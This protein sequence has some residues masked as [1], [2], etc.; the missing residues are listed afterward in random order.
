MKA[1]LN[2]HPRRLAPMGGKVHLTRANALGQ[3][4]HGAAKK[5]RVTAL[6][7]VAAAT[8]GALTL[9]GVTAAVAAVPAEIGPGVGITGVMDRG[10][11]WL[12]AVGGTAEAEA[13]GW[14]SWCISAG[15]LSPQGAPAVSVSYVDDPQLAW[16]IQAYEHVGTDV[17]RAAIAYLTHT[18]HETGSN[19][20][21][22]ETR[23]ARIIANTPQSVK[24]VAG[25]YI[26]EAA[27]K[28]GPYTAAPGGVDGA[29]TRVGTIWASPV[30]SNSGAPLVGL[31]MTVTLSGPAVFDTNGNADADRGET[32]VWN[33]QTPSERMPLKWVATGN[34]EVTWNYSYQALPRTTLTRF[35]ATGEVQDTLTYGAR[36]PSDPEEL[37][38]PGPPFQVLADF[39]P[40]IRTQ[41]ATTFV[42][43]GAA[44]VDQVTVAP[45]AGDTWAQINGTHV[46]VTAQ[47]TLYGPYAAPPARSATVPAGAPV[48]GTAEL[49][50][51][52][53]ST[54]DAA[55]SAVARGSGYYTW[56]WTIDK[57][58]QGPNGVYVRAD[59][60]HDF[61]LVAETHV[62]P[63]QPEVTTVV[64][65]RFVEKGKAFVDEVTFAPAA[66]D[67]WLARQ[68]GTPVETVWDGTLYGPFLVP[69]EQVDT[70]P[71]AAPV[72]ATTILIAS[73]AG[74]QSTDAAATASAPGFYTW[75]WEMDKATQ[76]VTSQPYIAGSVRTSFM[77][78][79]ET[80]SVRHTAAISTMVRDFNV[81]Q[82]GQIHDLV[83]VSGL[84]EDHSD[85]E[86]LGG[87]TGDVDEITHT[88]YG[89]LAA[90]PT[91]DL[92]LSTAPVL[93][94]ATSPAKNGSHVV[95]TGGEFQVAADNTAAGW[96]VVVSSFPGDD[97][98][99]A[100]ATSPGDR[101]EM[102]FV[103]TDRTTDVET[104]LV[105]DADAQVPAGQP[106][107]DTAH[108]TGTTVEGGYLEFEAYGPF[109]E[110]QEPAESPET[111]LW[112]SEQIP[113][114][115][116]GTYRSGVVTAELPDGAPW[117]DVYWVAAYYGPDSERIVRG[118]LG[119]PSE[120]TRVVEQ[121]EPLVT[122]LA[123]PESV[124]GSPSH[125]VAYV[126]G[127]VV[128]ASTLTFAAYRQH[129][130]DDVALDELVVDTSNTPTTIYHG[131]TYESPEVTFDAPGTYY[132]V[133]TLTG[134]DGEVLHVG[135][136]RL[137]G[138]TT[139]VVDVPVPP[140]AP[141]HEAAPGA[142]ASTGAQAS[143][144][145]GAALLML[146]AGLLLASIAQHRAAARRLV[147][148]AGAGDAPGD[149][150]TLPRG[151]L[152]GSASRT[153]GI[154]DAPDPSPG[155]QP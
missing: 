135:E 73:E 32:R 138:E 68:D 58:A 44:L 102:A 59:A 91:D 54:L 150:G 41:V 76:P 132:W 96:Y 110:G 93:G 109:V 131:G 62:V 42:D 120:I 90:Q 39:Q 97:R 152:G 89:P 40:E 149:A 140:V 85:F 55:A 106:F 144:A 145:A 22:A 101:M 61:G 45:A 133:E 98:L 71:G 26:A 29:G 123:V 27:S 35:K 155:R 119:D 34:G 103:P 113:A 65:E 136:P 53:P 92:D 118:E 69:T 153:A 14:L 10:T 6:S 15:L 21:P 78:E 1:R 43:K 18:R 115:R 112:T 38:V 16:V 79:D 20:V 122:T 105:T 88:A 11:T 13:A 100:F 117:G 70:T 9:S 139:T 148:A 141:P 84:P 31:P 137:P 116:A 81:V 63:F 99:D 134:P 143:T 130:G 5:R 111:L 121:P 52:G 30:T 33:G 17:S 107:K 19:G 128:D 60:T 146:V 12:G 94:V 3:P 46:P 51:A 57:E 126:S 87:W 49:T 48:A 147:G 80:S 64:D 82:G 95:G 74:V 124:L 67:L 129:A 114:S 104:W 2:V 142:L 86:G 24:D 154:P 47:G 125:D 23:T 127:P 75:V 36:A 28:A 4:S 37:I 25:Q 66:G 8:I 56:V 108:L 77:I 72:Q 151:S 50:F 83:T 7:M